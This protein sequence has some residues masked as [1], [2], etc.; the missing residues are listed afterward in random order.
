MNAPRLYV[1]GWH[2]WNRLRLELV[3]PVQRG[4]LYATVRLVGGTGRETSVPVCDL[5]VEAA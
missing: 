3:E 5:R 2:P 1:A 4:D